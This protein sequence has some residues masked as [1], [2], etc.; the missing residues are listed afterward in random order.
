MTTPVS[1]VTKPTV[2]D[3]IKNDIVE[4]LRES[5]A[6]AEAGEVDALLL[7]EKR[8]DGHWRDER[9]G[10]TNFPDAIGRLEI[11]KQAWITH[12]LGEKM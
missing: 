7:I 3:N 10:C 8:P 4:I 2:A 12:Y 1:L 11:V 6:R 9:S 5:L